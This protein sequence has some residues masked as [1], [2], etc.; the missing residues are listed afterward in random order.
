MDD[1]AHRCFLLRFFC[2]I[3]NCIAKRKR[4]NDFDGIM[5][6]ISV[7]LCLTECDWG[8]SLA[9]EEETHRYLLFFPLIRCIIKKKKLVGYLSMDTIKIK[10]QNTKM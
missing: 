3:A 1:L 6:S 2:I 8:E 7:Y 10:S 9:K 4:W 5:L